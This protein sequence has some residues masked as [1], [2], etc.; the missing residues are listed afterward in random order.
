MKKKI[1]LFTCMAFVILILCV[2]FLY[3]LFPTLSINNNYNLV[4]GVDFDIPNS[5]LKFYSIEY[6]GISTHLLGFK[7]AEKQKLGD[8]LLIDKKNGKI[9]SYRVGKNCIFITS[10]ILDVNA[11]VTDAIS[12]DVLNRINIGLSQ[13]KETEILINNKETSNP[14]IV[15][16]KDNI[17]FIDF[18][19]MLPE[20]KSKL[21]YYRVI[22]EDVLNVTP[23][24]TEEEIMILED[25]LPDVVEVFGI[26]EELIVPK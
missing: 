18:I 6:D 22:I 25:Y 2:V 16:K 20:S 14:Y 26:K 17:L 7:N 9:S 12:E 19:T 23:S 4:D 21:A 24:L 3:K 11:V 13:D 15:S 10:S 5:S 8:E 1:I